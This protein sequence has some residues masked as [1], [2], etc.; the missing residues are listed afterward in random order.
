MVTTKRCYEVT[1]LFERLAGRKEARKAAPV[2]QCTS[3]CTT[4]EAL[5]CSSDALA[6]LDLGGLGGVA[7]EQP[8]LEGM[9]ASGALG[10]RRGCSCAIS[11]PSGASQHGAPG[12]DKLDKFQKT[13]AAPVAR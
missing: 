6:S 3:Q 7:A 1:R 2:Q 11:L 8:T 9:R 4:N 10:P 5:R 13:I 12:A